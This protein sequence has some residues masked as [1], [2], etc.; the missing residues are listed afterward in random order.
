[1][2]I[3]STND[4]FPTSGSTNEDVVVNHNQD[5]YNNLYY[6]YECGKSFLEI[7]KEMGLDSGD[8]VTIRF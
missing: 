3:P 6:Q 2:G 8:D 4:L 1:M 7:C 5:D